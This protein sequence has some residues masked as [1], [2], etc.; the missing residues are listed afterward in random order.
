MSKEFMPLFLDFNEVTQDLSD[1]QCGRLIRALVSY[2]N[3]QEYPLQGA[4][5]IAFRF[6]KGYVDRN[7][8]L[9]KV[10][11]EAGAKGGQQTAANHSKM[12]QD[13]AKD[14]KMTINNDIHI[15]ENDD[16]KTVAAD[17]TIQEDHAHLIKAAEDAGFRISESVRNELLTLLTDHGLQKML[18]G[19]R[20]CSEHDAMSLAY[21]R[22]VLKGDAKKPKVAA[23]DYP[24]RP[25]DAVQAR[26]EAEQARRVAEYVSRREARTG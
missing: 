10:R 2:A 21:L 19:I 11:A 9:S 23:Q 17:D 25:Y 3:G 1:E 14:S 4:E 24:Q 26:I 5:M 16:I 15:Y 7:K 8:V 12:K 22:A 18:E 6:M 13:E 20:A